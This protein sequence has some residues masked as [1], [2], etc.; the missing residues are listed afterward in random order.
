M[1]TESDIRTKDFVFG[2]RSLLI[3]VLRSELDDLESKSTNKHLHSLTYLKE[4]VVKSEDIRLYMTSSSMTPQEVQT[5]SKGLFSSRIED[6][7]KRNVEF[8][9]T[10]TDFLVMCLIIFFL[11]L[12]NVDSN[13]SESTDSN[14]TIAISECAQRFWHIIQVQSS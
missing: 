1:I 12:K 4:M 11:S 14:R 6:T 5:M 2:N 8:K 13:L 3:D 7:K 10:M 9:K